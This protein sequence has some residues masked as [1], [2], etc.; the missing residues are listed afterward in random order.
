MCM[1][2]CIVKQVVFEVVHGI[3]FFIITPFHRD[4]LIECNSKSGEIIMEVS[5]DTGIRTMEYPLSISD[6]FMCSSFGLT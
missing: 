3:C 5:I 2:N 4:Q 6:A 1:N